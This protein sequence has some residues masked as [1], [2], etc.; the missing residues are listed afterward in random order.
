M[1][2]AF[3]TLRPAFTA[4][5]RVHLPMYVFVYVHVYMCLALK[6]FQRL[7]GC[8]CSD[9]LRNRS[10]F[11]VLQIAAI[12]FQYLVLLQRFRTSHCQM[13]T[14]FHGSKKV[15]WQSSMEYTE[16][17]TWNVNFSLAHKFFTTNPSLSIILSLLATWLH[18]SGDV[19][20]EPQ[21]VIWSCLSA[22]IWWKLMRCTTVTHDLDSMCR[23]IL[24]FERGNTHTHTH[25]MHKYGFL[26]FD[27]SDGEDSWWI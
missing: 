1:R 20:G 5:V 15:Q 18:G 14:R 22:L 23:S 8:R 24:Y 4:N 19:R 11:I 3:V 12:L 16:E 10:K 6:L 9:Y 27:S 25:C 17:Y 13:A 26:D 7:S 2:C 21:Q